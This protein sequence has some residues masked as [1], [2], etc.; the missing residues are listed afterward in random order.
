MLGARGMG[1]DPAADISLS[2]LRDSFRRLDGWWAESSDDFLLLDLVDLATL[3][4]G[5]LERDL[6]LELERDRF[7]LRMDLEEEEVEVEGATGLD[8]VVPGSS[9][10]FAM[11][12]AWGA[13]EV[14]A[15]LED[16]P[17]LDDCFAWSVLV[18]GCWGEQEG[19]SVHSTPPNLDPQIQ[20]V[21]SL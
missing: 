11:S 5:D 18:N 16:E 13:A 1:R 9:E 10:S 21:K 12:L 2:L 4:T 20:Q 7:L 6:D 14:L 15:E 3:T 19:Q 8:L 17:A